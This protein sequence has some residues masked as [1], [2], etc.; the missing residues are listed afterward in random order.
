MAGEY[1]TERVLQKLPKKLADAI[2]N[3]L[4]IALTGQPMTGVSVRHDMSE[5]VAAA[6]A[7]AGEQR[8]ADGLR[9]GDMVPVIPLS[10]PQNY[11]SPGEL[12][13]RS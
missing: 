2:R 7:N 10:G 4:R 13:M 8:Y 3:G 6:L 5:E 11:W 9:N 12:F 1:R